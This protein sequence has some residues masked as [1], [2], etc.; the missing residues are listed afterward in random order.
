[1]DSY[2]ICYDVSN[3]KRLRR[4]A[5]ACEDYGYRRQLSVFLVRVSATD[6]VRL[7]ARLYDAID[8]QE[9]QVLFIPLCANCVAGF[10]TL[11]RP[12][13]AVTARDVVVVV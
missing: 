2:L 12:T 8:Q 7:R 11:G 13:D 6:Y 3:P 1:M 9:D 10:D 5:K 4:V